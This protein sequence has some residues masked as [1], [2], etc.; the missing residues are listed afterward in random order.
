MLHTNK[1]KIKGFTLIELMLA[2]SLLMMIM[3]SGYYAYSLY[4]QKWQKRVD[5]FWKGT[6]QGIGLDALNKLYI[7]AVSYVIK[8]NE[9]KE[10][11]YFEGDQSRMRFV[12]YSPIFS[13]GTALVELEVQQSGETKRLI[14]REFNLLNKPVYTLE[15]FEQ[16][17]QWQKEVILF[18]DYNEISWSYYGWTSFEDALQQANIA[19]NIVTSELRKP[20]AQHKLATIR[21]LPVS[22]QL[23]LVKENNQSLFNIDLPNNTVFALIANFRNDA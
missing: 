13:N 6:N 16:I 22:I 12:S 5:I 19:G 8:N 11:I 23:T 10:S 21:I 18:Q 1:P 9:D 2:T 3:F 4:S 7:S 14:Y 20:Y 15:G 17:T